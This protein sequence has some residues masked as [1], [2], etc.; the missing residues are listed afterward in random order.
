MD[1]SS[2]EISTK[3]LVSIFGKTDSKLVFFGVEGVG[4]WAVPDINAVGI[5]QQRLG[6]LTLADMVSQ[7]GFEVTTDE[8]MFLTSITPKGGGYAA[9]V[10]S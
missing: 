4:G 8:D 7:L 6:W 1:K 10:L 3:L 5:F 9:Q 2:F